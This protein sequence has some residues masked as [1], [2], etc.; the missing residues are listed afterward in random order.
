MSDSFLLAS[1]TLLRPRTL[2]GAGAKSHA[3]TRP[4]ATR[5]KDSVCTED[6]DG[7]ID[8]SFDSPTTGNPLDL[9][10][11]REENEEVS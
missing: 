10:I 4:I 2:Y 1:G 5:K 8:A 11:E 3:E 7:H 6:I 9:L